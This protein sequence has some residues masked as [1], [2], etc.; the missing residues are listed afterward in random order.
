MATATKLT[1]NRPASRVINGVRVAFILPISMKPAGDSDCSEPPAGHKL[2]PRRGAGRGAGR[3][4]WHPGP[5]WNTTR[6][7]VSAGNSWIACVTG[8]VAAI[9][10]LRSDPAPTKGA[11]RAICRTGPQALSSCPGVDGVAAHLER[12][13]NQDFKVH[14]ASV[15]LD[16]Q[17]L[18]D[19]GHSLRIQVA[20]SL[21]HLVRMIRVVVNVVGRGQE[22]IRIRGRPTSG[23]VL[24]LLNA[25]WVQMVSP[26][27]E[28]VI[29]NR[30]V[31][32][33]TVLHLRCET[34][35]YLA[36]SD[37]VVAL[38]VASVNTVPV[39]FAPD[40]DHCAGQTR[41]SQRSR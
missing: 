5:G 28:I 31:E 12:I 8:L 20:T 2:S 38:R 37:S 25:H 10:A 4:T 32:N 9:L 17:V 19:G 14:L 1:K 35:H 24:Q 29:P 39:R 41:S 7:I 11:E 22:Q 34:V 23:K 3:T 6:S 40:R 16:R 21:N 18:L 15:H 27:V 26:L 30:L 36:T 33:M 13:V